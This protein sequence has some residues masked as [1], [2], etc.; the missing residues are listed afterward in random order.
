MVYERLCGRPFGKDDHV[1]PRLSANGVFKLCESMT[2]RSFSE[3]LAKWLDLAHMI[4]IVGGGS[5]GHH[6]LH[7]FRRGALQHFFMLTINGK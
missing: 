7:C 1:F 4:P 6:T 3:L 2:H 5:L